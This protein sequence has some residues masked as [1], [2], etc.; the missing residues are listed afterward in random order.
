MD[1]LHSADDLGQWR[2]ALPGEQNLGF[3]PTMGALHAG[4]GSLF[5]RAGAECAV[6]LASIFVNPLQFN[7]G[8][9]FERYPRTLDEDCEFLES[10]GVAAVYLPDR[11][12]MYGSDFDTAVTP[13]RAGDIWEGRFRPGHFA[14]MLTAVLKLLQRA[15]ADA[16][17]FGE[18]DAQQLFLVRQMVKD[19]DLTVK[20]CGCETVRESDGLALSSRNAFLNPEQRQQSLVL[21]QALQVAAQAWQEGCRVPSAM[22][23]AMRKVLEQTP[24]VAVEYCAVVDDLDFQSARQDQAGVWRAIVAARVGETRLL[25]NQSLGNSNE[26]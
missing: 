7:K 17:Y 10:K 8:K 9:D 15:Q 5:D 11:Q 18:K 16:A 26:A 23:S 22:E 2:A 6:V 20:I 3:V 25:D 19:L 14:G 12:D 1:R 24:K 4:H 13:G 21:F